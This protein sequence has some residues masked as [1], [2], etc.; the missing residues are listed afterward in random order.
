[1]SVIL[2]YSATPEGSTWIASDT[3]A[4]SGTLRLDCGPKWILHGPWAAGIAGF[5]RSANLID[6]NRARLLDGL[7]GPYDFVERVQALFRSDGYREERDERGPANLGQVLL[8][9]TAGR[10]WI[11]GGDF[12]V[13]EVPAGQLWAEGSGRELAIGAGHALVRQRP[14]PDGEEIVRR[15]IDAALAFDTSCGG[16]AWVAELAPGP[17]PRRRRRPP[18]R[19]KR[20]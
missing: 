20:R 16:E 7:D 8:L 2:A 14:L 18:A 9:A 1:M 19:G 5:L 15:A 4:T 6:E 13:A 10:S 17:A 3:M 12:S 11:V